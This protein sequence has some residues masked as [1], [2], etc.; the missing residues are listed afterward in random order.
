MDGKIHGTQNTEIARLYIVE[1]LKTLL[2]T[3]I[4]VTRLCKKFY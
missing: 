3:S 2:N 4:K 1:Y